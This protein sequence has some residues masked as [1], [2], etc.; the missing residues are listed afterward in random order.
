MV[1]MWG[2]PPFSDQLEHASRH[3]RAEQ[4]IKER[5]GRLS[6]AGLAATISAYRWALEKT[7]GDWQL[8]HNFGMFWLFQGDFAKAAQELEF[9]VRT[10]PHLAANRL[11]VASALARSG[12]TKEAVEQLEAALRIDPQFTPAREALA[13]VRTGRLK[14]N[15]LPSGGPSR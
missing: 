6:A 15:P 1:R 9:E 13:M 2:G 12:R 5:A 8:H 14:A 4:E 7:P 3:S 10:F 11:P